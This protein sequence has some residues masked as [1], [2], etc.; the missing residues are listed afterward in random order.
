MKK[1]AIIAFTIIM[2]FVM[3]TQIFAQGL[4]SYDFVIDGIEICIQS[5]EYLT[6]EEAYEYALILITNQ[7]NQDPKGAWCTINGHS[8]A[9]TTAT[10]TQHKYYSV[11]P[12]CLQRTYLIQTCT[13]C[14]YQTSTLISS[15]R[16]NCCS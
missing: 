5:N 7:N 4:Y 1:I 3:G 8:M 10:T 6:Q 15:T 11:A 9:S 14:G 16:I 2:V 13:V 12:R